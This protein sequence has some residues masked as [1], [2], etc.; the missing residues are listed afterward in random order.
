MDIEVKVGLG[1]MALLAVIGTTT[2]FEE[3]S[4]KKAYAEEQCLLQ[5]NTVNYRQPDKIIFCLDKATGL[6]ERLK[7]LK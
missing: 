5:Y 4:R 2:Y 1:F 3:K 7:D 6:Y